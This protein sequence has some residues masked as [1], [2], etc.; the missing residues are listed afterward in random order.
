MKIEA[1][2]D[3]AMS[4]EALFDSMVRYPV[5]EGLGDFPG[6]S[7]ER[8]DDLTAPG[9][10]MRWRLRFGYRGHDY[11]TE[12]RL[13]RFERADAMEF[14]GAAGGLTAR[15]QLALI[16]VSS[17]MTRLGLTVEPRAG[18]LAGRALLQGLKLRRGRIEERLSGFLG[19]YAR[20][21]ERGAGPG[22]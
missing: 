18:N 6:I 14:D 2:Q 20:R 1:R 17:T 11:E 9:T 16:P 21:L 7:V 8:L 3:V 13:T 12:T 10:G 5:V 4:A 19:D 22:A 15:W